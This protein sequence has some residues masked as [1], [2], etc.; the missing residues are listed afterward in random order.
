MRA[1]RSTFP[2]DPTDPESLT[3]SPPRPLTLR[4]PGL[5]ARLRT[6]RRS[7]L[8][9]VGYSAAGISLI[10]GWGWRPAHR[11]DMT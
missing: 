11:G 8:N 1:V 9:A 10:A 4:Q 2:G 5:F 3:D 6:L 7:W